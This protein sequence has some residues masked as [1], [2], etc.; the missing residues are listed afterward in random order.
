MRI[1]SLSSI[2]F[3]SLGRLRPGNIGACILVPA[4]RAVEGE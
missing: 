4:A 3:A 2:G 1:V